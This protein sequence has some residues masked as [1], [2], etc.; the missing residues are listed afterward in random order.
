MSRDKEKRRNK[1]YKN[2]YVTPINS[3]DNNEI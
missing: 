1:H 3:I 2:I